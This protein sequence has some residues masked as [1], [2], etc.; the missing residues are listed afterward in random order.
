MSPLFARPGTMLVG[1]YDG[2]I[3]HGVFVVSVDGQM[4]EDRLPD[5]ANRPATEARMHHPEVAEPLRQVAPRDARSIAIQHSLHKQT[6]IHGWPPYC[7]APPW[8]KI[9]DPIPLIVPQ[10][11]TPYRHPLKLKSAPT[12]AYSQFDD[13]PYAGPGKR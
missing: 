9:L 12:L 2:R 4:L 7:T 1:A 5:P 3:D 13:T 8:Q 6:T 10:P 11:V